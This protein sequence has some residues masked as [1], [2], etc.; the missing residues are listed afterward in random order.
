MEAQQTAHGVRHD[1]YGQYR[2]YCTRRL[3]RLSHS[4]EAK[5]HLVCS[6]KFASESPKGMSRH[7]FCSRK[8]D[9]LMQDD[10]AHEHVLWYLFVL[11]ERCWAHAKEYQKSQNQANARKK[12]KKAKQW[13][14][15]LSEMAAK[16][17]TE[18]T[19]WEC[20]AYASWMV[21]NHALES[22]DYKVSN[23][24]NGNVFSPLL[25]KERLNQHILRS[26]DGR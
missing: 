7:A 1:D 24:G 25:E 26:T 9:T 6:S 2:S 19:Q 13:A 5:Q 10:A 11:A 18:T 23:W 3:S 12:L 22:T 14:V 16:S 15:R 21:A 8:D 20:Q 4:P 17:A